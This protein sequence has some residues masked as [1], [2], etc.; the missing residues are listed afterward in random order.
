LESTRQWILKQ[1]D[2]STMQ[3]DILG[4]HFGDLGACKERR[5]RL[6]R[7][8]AAEMSAEPIDPPRQTGL[9]GLCAP[10]P[11]TARR[12]RPSGELLLWLAC[13]ERRKKERNTPKFFLA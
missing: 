4:E 11:C 9:M 2:W 10:K 8:I 12:G 3:R 6:Y 1:R 13:G 5:K 7:L